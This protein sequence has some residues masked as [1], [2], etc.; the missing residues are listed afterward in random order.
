MTDLNAF[1]AEHVM[2]YHKYSDGCIYLYD[3]DGKNNPVVGKGMFK[4]FSFIS[5]YEPFNDLPVWNPRKN[6]EQALS[7][8]EEATRKTGRIFSIQTTDSKGKYL[9]SVWVNNNP[10]SWG[11]SLEEVPA[12]LCH[13]IKQA[14]ESADGH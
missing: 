8:A 11:I 12:A 10:K 2:Q 14:V 9:W 5:D 6:I 3:E 7:C 13:E 1:L 4:V